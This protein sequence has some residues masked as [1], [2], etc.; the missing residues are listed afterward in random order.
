MQLSLQHVLPA[1]LE[2]HLKTATSGVFATECT[3][4]TAT[5]YLVTAASGKGKSTFMHILYGLR[6]DYTG[7]AAI[8]GTNI[9]TF[10]PDDWS[11]LRQAKISMVF[12]DLRLFLPLTVE[13]NILVKAALTPEI[14]YATKAKQ[15]ATQLGIENL[16]QQT[17]ETLSYGQRQRVAILRALCQP[18]EVLLLDEPF[19]HLDTQNIQIATQLIEEQRSQ[20]NASLIFVSLG[21]TYGMHFDQHVT[22]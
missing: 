12:Q 19:S 3:F 17:C 1:P 22:L 9:K 2:M 5:K 10:A 14:D 6:N 7:T 15:W 13:Q 8:N 20:N 4:R 21:D 18:F 16:W 11:A